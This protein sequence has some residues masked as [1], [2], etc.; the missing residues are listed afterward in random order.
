MPD[1]V[2]GRAPTR[3]DLAG[4]TMDLWPLY[5]LHERPLTVNAAIDL[6]ARARIE[7]TAG[8]AIEVISRDRD[9]RVRAET[10]EH[11][12]RDPAAAGGAIEFPLRL[13]AHFLGGRGAPARGDG[14]LSC[15]ITTDCQAPAGSGLGGSSAL[16]IAL[17]SV[18]NRYTG[19][20]L[21]SDRLL[22]LTRAIETQVLKIPT[23][24]QDYHPALLGGILALHYGVEGTR[25][26]RLAVDVEALRRHTVLV[27]TGVSRSSGV[28]NWD[29]IKRHLD[30]DR[31]VRDAL[32]RIN[33]ATHAMR[34]ALLAGDWDAA[35]AALAEE[36]EAR[37]RMSP[38]VTTPAIDGMIGAARALGGQAGK[39]CGAGGGGC[40]VLW[41][42]EGS[43]QAVV[44]GITGLGGRVLDFRYVTEG[45]VVTEP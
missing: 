25:A 19:R 20:G 28:S 1:R 35:G 7:T 10:P 45:V 15:R 3:I 9:C 4:G 43:R 23:G 12:G 36:W 38:K 24:E 21:E 11:L 34:E 27:F 22:S 17:A 31:E 39:V 42:R 29:M 37:R 40:L 30:G 18:L 32:E 41:V 13:A 16:G 6:F 8:G 5:L 26:E 2:E 14:S 44:E 33:G